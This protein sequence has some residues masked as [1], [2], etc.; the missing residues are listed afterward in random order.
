MIVIVCGLPGS[1]KTTLATGLRRR[2]ADRGHA[3]D[4]LHSD[5]YERRPYDRMYERVAD[6]TEGCADDTEGR[7]DHDGNWILD[8]TFFRREWRNRFY[9]I[10]DTYEVW[11]KASLTTC[12]ERN[13]RRADPISETGVRTI[14]G[15]FEPPRA[16]L[17][18]D[19]ETLDV[20]TALDR[21]EAAV[22]GW[23]DD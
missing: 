21:L 12:L 5:D 11:V 2:L 17:E 16:D 20:D 14:H 8:G 7:A 13:R 1:G 18:L 6:D 19:T 22:L 23:L 9:R 3:F 15:Q 10:D 4:L